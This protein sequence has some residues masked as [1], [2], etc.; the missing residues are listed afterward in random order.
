MQ[1]LPYFIFMWLYN[2]PDTVDAPPDFIYD[3]YYRLHN[4]I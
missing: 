3:F 4:Y 1:N 2:N